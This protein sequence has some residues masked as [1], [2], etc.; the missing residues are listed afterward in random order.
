M[1]NTLLIEYSP[2]NFSTVGLRRIAARAKEINSKLIILQT[3]PCEIIWRYGG[4]K[5]ILD[6]LFETGAGLVYC[7]Y[8]EF[9]ENGNCKPVVLIDLQEGSLRDDFEF[10]SIMVFDAKT[11]EEGLNTIGEYNFAALY[12]LRLWIMRNRQI[13]HINEFL[14]TSKLIKQHS[15]SQFDYVDSRN[16]AAQI[17]L[18]AA[19]TLHLKSVGAWLPPE[20]PEELFD[21]K[22]FSV[23]A[24]VI[25]PVKNRVKTIKSAVESVLRQKA[26]FKYN[27]II[28]D[29]HSD[30]GTSEILDQYSDPRV[31]H[32]VPDRDDLG[33]GGCWNYGASLPCCG[34]FVLQLD[35][36]D[37][38]SHDG[39]IQLI[40][41][42]F[43][44]QKCAMLVGSYMLTDFNLKQIPP[45]VIDHREWTPSNGPNNALRI[46]GLGAPRCFYTPILKNL[47][48]PNTSY[49]EDY[50]LA[51]RISRTHKIGRI[52]DTLYFCRRWEDNSDAS[53]SIAKV[54]AHNFYKDSIRTQELLARK[55]LMSNK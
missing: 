30:D 34:K 5:R 3:H 9:L 51:L 8:Y 22:T 47:M 27:V 25:I 49:G 7:D 6:I 14:Y 41:D 39:V 55:R 48:L 32:V 13:L 36:D 54:N 43:Y 24:S 40:V 2:D 10:G 37:V 21:E 31:I 46:N 44:N 1:D 33:I 28:V 52:Y 23:E 26:N 50:A 19:C 35:S 17:E 53:L 11:F 16:R 4:Y 42:E 18:E 15:I 12:A 45:G 29:N 38:Y 20:R